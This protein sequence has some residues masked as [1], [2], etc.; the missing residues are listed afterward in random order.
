MKK[1][2][3][4][5]MLF[6]SFHS[7]SNTE[8][9]SYFKTAREAN[10]N[11]VL[12]VFFRIFYALSE[13]SFP[14]KNCPLSLQGDFEYKS[15][16]NDDVHLQGFKITSFDEDNQVITIDDFQKLKRSVDKKNKLVYEYGNYKDLRISKYTSK[17]KIFPNVSK[18]R[19][20]SFFQTVGNG[21]MQFDALYD[22]REYEN[23]DE[24]Y[25]FT[26]CPYEITMM[27]VTK[28]IKHNNLT[29]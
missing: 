18:V 3:F 10:D 12:T 9:H 4:A 6:T 16:S 5:F 27:V 13:S 2:I 23:N 26:T 22:H 15:Y 20:Y 8:I 14:K 1:I 29:K 24:K 7:F 19:S 28:I 11:N 21:W 17:Y 25:N